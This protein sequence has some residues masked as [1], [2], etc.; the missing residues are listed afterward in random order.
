MLLQKARAVLEGQVGSERAP[1]K[2]IKS[3]MVKLLQ[4]GRVTSSLGQLGKHC[5]LYTK[6]DTQV[7]WCVPAVPSGE[8]WN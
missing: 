8:A 7:W 6:G 2:N 5:E 1:A 3:Y 4:L